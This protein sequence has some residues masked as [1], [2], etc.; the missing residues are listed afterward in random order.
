MAA[1]P[2]KISCD[3]AFDSCGT[4]VRVKQRPFGEANDDRL[5]I[6]CK[7]LLAFILSAKESIECGAVGSYELEIVLIF[8]ARI[9][10][11]V[12]RI[13]YDQGI[14]GVIVFNIFM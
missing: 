10:P 9:D 14:C 2:N 7:I 3:K 4:E 6:F 5:R 12:K 13:V 1:R 8:I 11:S